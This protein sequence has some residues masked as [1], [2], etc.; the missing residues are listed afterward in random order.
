MRIG[1]DRK[2]AER[3]A[4]E[5]NAQLAHGVPS[6]FGFERVRVE[7]LRRLWLEHH[8]MVLRSSVATVNRYRAA[9]EHLVR[10]IRE[11]HPSLTA[12]AFT[13]RIAEAMVKYLRQTEVTPNGHEQAKKRLLRDKG[14][15][16]ILG[17]CRSLF[18]YA[19]KQ[20]HLPP[21]AV[22]P[23]AELGI[24]KMQI[25]DAKPTGILTQAEEAAFLAASDLWQFRVFFTLAFTGMRP[26]ELCHLLVEDVDPDK[27]LLY[28]RNRPGLGWKTKT[29]N[30][31]RVYLFD[32]LAAVVR[33]AAGNRSCGSLFLARRY[34]GGGE[35]P[36][37]AGVGARELATELHTRV[38][39]GGAVLSRLAQDREAKRLWWDMGAVTPKQV[40]REF[41]SVAKRIGR[42]DLT[43]PKLWRHQMATAM[44]AA[45]VDPFVRKEV[46]GH[47]RLEMTGRY[48]H[49]AD[50]TLGRE[51]AKVAS[52]REAALAVARRSLG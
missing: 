7:E 13:P 25:E 52:M 28:I 32:E 45:D 16:F 46:I 40:R 36:R 41:I 12:D 38:A 14:L 20:R 29:R 35:L 3:R 48:T 43:C 49:T 11:K 4:A 30:E 18:N 2:E 6:S 39:A 50:S 9:T 1:P 31:R 34:A 37:L 22:N 51:M 15:I 47:T 8:E 26:G 42:P 24:E 21:Y 5:I 23:F 10:F 44:Q 17:T 19:A 33:E 27:K